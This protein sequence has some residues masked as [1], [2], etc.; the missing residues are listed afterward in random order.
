MQQRMCQTPKRHLVAPGE[1]PLT[2]G[3]APTSGA[4]TEGP[5]L[6]RATPSGA[7]GPRAARS[8]SLDGSV[9]HHPLGILVHR[10][11]RQDIPAATRVVADDRVL[12]A[13]GAVVVVAD[14]EDGAAVGVD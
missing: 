6:R 2:S 11:P 13:Q 14:E 7:S 4:V 10:D 5:D 8:R 1:D 9:R 3:R 12:D